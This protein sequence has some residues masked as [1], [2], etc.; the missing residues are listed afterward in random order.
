MSSL[1]ELDHVHIRIASPETVLKW[2]YGEVTKPETINY[3]THRPEKDGLFCERIFGPSKDYMCA[4]YC[5]KYDK[6]NHKGI[7][8]ENCGVEIQSSMVRRE[9]MGHIDL[10]APV[11]HFWYFPK[12]TNNYIASLLDIQPKELD[13]VIYCKTYMVVD[14]GDT[15]LERLQLLNGREYTEALKEHHGQFKVGIGAEVI[16]ELL[17]ELDLEK[18]QQSLKE[19]IDQ[20][21]TLKRRKLI[22]RLKVVDSFLH[23]GNKPEWMIMDYLPV[24]PPD[25]RPMVLLDG[26]RFATSDLNDFY[27]RIINRNI[28][29]KKLI[30]GGAPDVIIK[31]EKRL[32]QEGVDSLIANHRR[33]QHSYKGPGNRV[34]KSLSETLEGKQGLF[35]QNLLGKRVDFSGRSV[36]TV[37]PT[38]RLNQCGLPRQMAIELFKP[39]VI[40]ELIRR[41]HVEKPEQA[42]RMI[43]RKE[44]VIWDVLEDVV[45]HHPVLLNRAPTL[46]KL[47]IRAFEVVIIE[48]E[49]ITLHPLVCDGY[50]A[51]F[52]GDQMA[53]H[54][55]MSI[56]AQVEARV[57]L[58]APENLLHPQNGE[59][60]VTPSQDMVLGCAYLSVEKDGGRGEGMVY[61]SQ[62]KAIRAY[63]EKEIE[64]HSKIILFISDDPKFK[65]GNYIVTTVG[66]ILLNGIMPLHIPYINGENVGTE[67]DR[68]FDSIGEA[69]GYVTAFSAKP[70]KKGLL[71]KIIGHVFDYATHDE[72]IVMLDGMK[73]IGFKY[74]TI[75]GLTISLFDIKIPDS[76]PLM[77]D[78][79]EEKIKA[80]E[81]YYGIGQITDEERYEAV[82]SLWTKT[83]EKVAEESV[84]S[85]YEDP[86][87]PICMMLDSGARGNAGQYRQLAGM[88]GLMANPDGKTIEK[89]IKANF[90]EGL[91]VFEFFISTHGARKGLADTSLRV[92]DS[93]YLTRRMVDVAQDVVVTEEDCGTELYKLITKIGDVM[94]L[95]ER[96]TGRHLAKTMHES[97]GTVIAEK[98]TLITSDLARELASH[99]EEIPIRNVLSCEAEQG[100][101]ASCYGMNY[102][103]RDVVEI[104][105]AVGIVAAQSIGEPGTQLTMRTFH[106]GGVAGD[107]ITQGLPRVEE[108]FEARK[109]EDSNPQK[110]KKA[111]LSDVSGVAEIKE[112]G[113]LKEVLIYPDNGE[114][115]KVFRIPFGKKV[116]VSDGERVEIG[117]A[118]TLA[119]VNP[120]ELLKLKGM[121]AVQEYLIR[122]IQLVYKSQGVDI[123]D[124]HIECIVR[125]MCKRV[126]VTNPGDAKVAIGKLMSLRNV[127]RMNQELEKNKQ[128]PIAFL[129][130]I[131]G[132]SEASMSSESFL[133]AASFQ[134]TSKALTVAAIEG[135]KDYL[136]GLKESLIAGKV[137]PA[138]TGIYHSQN[139]K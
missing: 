54:V 89:P 38:L 131:Q 21:K 105:E 59:S 80:V 120:H 39:F 78:Q 74:A 58:L 116:I 110:S 111:I 37:G 112:K 52:D 19:E 42:T 9:R 123:G 5:G 48:G 35:R 137:I 44:D 95:E 129:P 68:V 84:K 75:G 90:T 56:E 73:D 122:E 70:L 119:P 41:E 66:K 18:L 113:R 17:E 13:S 65:K 25:M 118:L 53:V 2:S 115:A 98:G 97:N 79:T 51:D 67:P 50:N 16:K 7:V 33:G 132:I 62:F 107:D 32:L 87:N 127:M 60:A 91:T 36:I 11:A 45:K 29:L 23:S 55:P 63:E 69:Q 6:K 14:P 77:I 26:G 92:A 81:Y 15:P 76:K 3:K 83:S 12:T 102:A 10:A 71:K 106:S 125:Q 94:T 61:G 103:T 101:C 1:N 57:L 20:T 22:K 85:L 4:Q 135:K 96:I 126:I 64:L 130:K 31:N 47:S 134:E 139:M 104:G 86:F 108:I 34:L 30:D 93:G 28:R 43:R 72:T 128:E 27:R 133:S 138:G 109:L 99:H 124:K 8:C 88:R 117:Q 136:I 82:I 100:V 24:I 46:H 49:A 114:E 121:D 40:H